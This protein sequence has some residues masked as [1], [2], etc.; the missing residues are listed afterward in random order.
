MSTLW[1][2]V[3]RSCE[4]SL[5]RCREPSDEGL[6]VA[7]LTQKLAL[8]SPVQSALEGCAG[9]SEGGPL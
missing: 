4:D 3:G 9:R 2:Q 8:P 7:D 1:S 6:L 5:E